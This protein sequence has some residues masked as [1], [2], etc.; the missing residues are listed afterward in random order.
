VSISAPVELIA[1]VT[2]TA[3]VA[4]VTSAPNT[5]AIKAGD[6]VMI[7]GFYGTT[8][9]N[10][11]SASDSLGNT[12]LNGN[13]AT[14]SSDRIKPFI[15]Q[16]PYDVAIGG[17][18]LTVTMSAANTNLKAIA[19]CVFSGAY[20]YDA[21]LAGVTATSA[22]PTMTFPQLAAETEL[23]IGVIRMQ[24]ASIN[25]YPA[26]WNYVTGF[27]HGGTFATEIVYGM[28]NRKTA[29]TPTWT[30]S[31]SVV[32]STSALSFSEARDFRSMLLLGVG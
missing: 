13:Q 8:G 30:L 20:S 10:V 18:T 28:V 1:P 2:S 31:S 15:F 27:N 11:N 24:N 4:T 5:V 6:W 32:W 7:M 14:S 22:A 12:Y 21:V 29:V 23:Q 26:G 19:A 25:A 17:L 16:Y 3:N 9:V